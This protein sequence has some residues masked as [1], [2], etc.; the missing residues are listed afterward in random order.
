MRWPTDGGSADPFPD[1]YFLCAILRTEDKGVAH[2]YGLGVS[3]DQRIAVQWH[4]L[5]AVQDSPESNYHLGLM[6]AHGRGFAQDLSGAAI[7]FQKAKNN[8]L[9]RDVDARQT[10]LTYD[11]FV[12]PASR[13]KKCSTA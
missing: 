8:V 5:A 3:K 6:K 2:E 10:F 12:V 4:S 7:H 9:N 1:L 13:W 11:V